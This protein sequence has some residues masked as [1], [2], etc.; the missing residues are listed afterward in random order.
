MVYY[1]TV[2][3]AS[4]ETAGFERTRVLKPVAHTLIVIGDAIVSVQPVPVA[5][6]FVEN[7]QRLGFSLANRW[8]RNLQTSE[9]SFNQQARIKQEHSLLFTK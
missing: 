2:V 4:I 9:E 3:L 1:R 6:R 8:L 7:F 5:N